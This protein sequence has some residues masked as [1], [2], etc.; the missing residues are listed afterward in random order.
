MDPGAAGREAAVVAD[1][2]FRFVE[3]GAGESGGFY[4]EGARIDW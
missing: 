3:S 4:R 2:I 1:E